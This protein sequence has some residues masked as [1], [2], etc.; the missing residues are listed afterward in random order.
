MHQPQRG[1]MAVCHWGRACLSLDYAVSQD[2]TQ[3]QLEFLF[4]ELLGP[5]GMEGQRMSRLAEAT[6]LFFYLLNHKH[7]ELI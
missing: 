6:S 5:C 4:Q 7:L 2:Q 1:Y 3:S